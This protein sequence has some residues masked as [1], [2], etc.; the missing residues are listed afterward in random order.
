VAQEP[1]HSVDGGVG[2]KVGGRE[3][4]ERGQQED[5]KE[6]GGGDVKR[7][8]RKQ[9]AAGRG[10]RKEE[11]V[12]SGGGGG[13]EEGGKKATLPQHEQRHDKQEMWTEEK[14]RMET[15]NTCSDAA[16]GKRRKEK[17]AAEE[18]K[19]EKSQSIK[20]LE[21]AMEP[22]PETEAGYDESEPLK[23]TMLPGPDLPWDDKFD[24]NL[25]KLYEYKR[26]KGARGP[27]VGREGGREGGGWVGGWGGREGGATEQLPS[28]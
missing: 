23:A 28:S 25:K 1:R 26:E 5:G 27:G 20:N 4:E 16:R 15:Q 13:K 18:E 12:C 22:K 10:G 2:G 6:G 3:Q 14:M 24:I 11:E 19:G 8:E 9:A 7:M 17:H 21:P